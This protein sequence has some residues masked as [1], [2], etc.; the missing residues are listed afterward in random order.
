[1]ITALPGWRVACQRVWSL[2]RHHTY[3]N[4]HSSVPGMGK[5]NTGLLISK[6]DIKRSKEKAQGYEWI[7]PSNP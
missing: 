3:G 6:Q 1:M 7:L 5:Y 2:G 4:L